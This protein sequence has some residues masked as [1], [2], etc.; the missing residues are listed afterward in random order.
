MIATKRFVTRFSKG[1]LVFAAKTTLRPA[2]DF[3][4]SLLDAGDL[5]RSLH[6]APFICS[7]LLAGVMVRGVGFVSM[8]QYWAGVAFVPFVEFRVGITSGLSATL[9][10]LYFKARLAEH[11]SQRLG[12]LSTSAQ[13]AIV[14]V[15]SHCGV[16]KRTYID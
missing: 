14:R 4:R 11:C 7:F 6:T 13:I 10:S 8:V 1:W 5:R 15:N 16:D 2:R 12:C 3:Q 9:S